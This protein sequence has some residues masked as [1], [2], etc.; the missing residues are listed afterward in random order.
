MPVDASLA[1]REYPAPAP[2]DVTEERVAQFVAAVGEP[3]GS[4]P[5]TFPIVLA[6]EAMQAFLTA[7]QVDLHRIVHG[8]QRFAYERPLRIGDV[9]SA[10]MTVTG[11]R[12]LGG[13]DVV[14]TSCEI[15][16]AAGELVCT[17]KAT[18]VHG[19]A[20]DDET[21]GDETGEERGGAA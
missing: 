21:G 15:R 4:I 14:A 2:L 19:P 3:A 13:A 10:V 12:S 1:G 8:E 5:P 9:V 16:D 17:G 18:L 20:G 11:V 6:F 7:E